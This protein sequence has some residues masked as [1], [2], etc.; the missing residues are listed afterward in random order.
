MLRA[1]KKFSFIGPL[2][3][4][5]E[6]PKI[7]IPS[8]LLRK[9]YDYWE[10]NIPENVHTYTFVEDVNE[11]LKSSGTLYHQWFWP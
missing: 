9:L 11:W 5:D 1:K 3:P 7:C 8:L 4:A 6:P 10:K 2:K